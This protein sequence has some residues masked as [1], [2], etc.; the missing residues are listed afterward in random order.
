MR[1]FLHERYGDARP[2][3]S[4]IHHRQIYDYFRVEE[5]PAVRLHKLTPT[6]RPPP[7]FL[8]GKREGLQWQAS[9]ARSLEGLVPVRRLALSDLVR[10]RSLDRFLHKRGHKRRSLLRSVGANAP[11]TSDPI[12][13]WADVYHSVTNSGASA[14]LNI[15]KPEL[16]PGQNFSLSQIW[17][18]ADGPLGRQTVE[19]GWHIYPALTN[20]NEPA[21][22][23]YWTRDGYQ[24]TGSYNGFG[25]DFKIISQN[26][27]LGAPI[28][29]VSIANGAQTEVL[30]ALKFYQGN[31]WVYIGGDQNENAVGYFPCSLYQGGPLGA[32]TATE[33]DFGGEVCGGPP[34]PP[35]GSGAFAAGAYQKASYQRGLGILA[36]DGS[37]VAPLNLLADD[38]HPNDFTV[39]AGSSDSWGYYMFF[40]GPGGS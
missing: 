7:G 35:M 27:V 5:Q 24:Q 18:V 12:H 11:G 10:F 29:D 4:R 39:T 22:F 14:T 23:C 37:A 31:W 6:E 3:T 36:A 32:G 15:W 13:R 34:F 25:G 26:T 19:V 28:T 16:T 2:V 33:V 20:H 17:C 21:M 38:E 9:R 8:G 1:A 30:C 40:G